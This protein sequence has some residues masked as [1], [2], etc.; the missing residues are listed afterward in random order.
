MNRVAEAVAG[1]EEILAAT[2]YES[3]LADP[4]GKREQQGYAA[5]GWPLVSTRKVLMRPEHLA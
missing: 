1:L 4:T 3:R 5:S 2:K